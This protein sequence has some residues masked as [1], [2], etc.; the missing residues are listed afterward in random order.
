MELALE[1]GLAA[2]VAGLVLFAG[3]VRRNNPGVALEGRPAL[4]KSDKLRYGIGFALIA[5]ISLA[6]LIL[7]R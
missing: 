5:V 1:I 4:S 2:V 7:D 3:H 6:W